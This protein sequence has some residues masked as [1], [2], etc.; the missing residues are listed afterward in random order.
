MIK[1]LFGIISVCVILSTAC[2]VTLLAQDIDKID[3]PKL[4][5][6]KI[7][8]VDKVTLENGM[9]L[10]LLEDKSLP[11]FNV[12]VR[13]NCGSYLEGADKVGLA[14]V[15][16]TVMRTGGGKCSPVARK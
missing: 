12:N 5:K 4:N 2:G 11:V 16:G 8:D 6:L 13:I 1:R 7:P 14:S 10:Y 9:R 3:F 15:C